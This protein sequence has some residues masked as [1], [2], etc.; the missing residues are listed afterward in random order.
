MRVISVAG[1]VLAEIAETETV[2]VPAMCGIAERAEIGVV[3]RHDRHCA[4]RFYQPVELFHRL[5]D[6]RY[7]LDNMDGPQLIERLIAK[8]I[9]KSIEIGN[10]V[11]PRARVAV[12]ADRARKFVDSTA[13]VEDA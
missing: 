4:A 7:V 10:H 12:E 9:R 8:G 6:V 3:G 1:I 11:R 5:H 13:D 2:E